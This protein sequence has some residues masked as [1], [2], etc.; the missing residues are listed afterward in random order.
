MTR[1]NINVVITFILLN[2]NTNKTCLRHFTWKVKLEL[3]YHKFQVCWHWGDLAPS[4]IIKLQIANLI[5]F[6]STL[7]L[8]LHHCL[9]LWT[10]SSDCKS[11]LPHF[12][13]LPDGSGNNLFT[14]II[15]SF[16]NSFQGQYAQKTIAWK[17]YLGT[18]CT[19]IKHI[20]WV[21]CVS[22]LQYFLA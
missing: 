7:T 13:P 14:M 2:N 21:S 16:G 18:K 19:L 10:P 6:C 20:H 17:P 8:S 4:A 15:F 11:F 3:Q 12:E 9:S 22:C 1:K 5:D